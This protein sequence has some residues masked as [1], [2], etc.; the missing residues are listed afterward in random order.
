MK[1]LYFV[2]HGETPLN[3]EKLFSGQIETPLTKKGVAQARTTAKLIKQ[4]I[5]KIDLIIAS[6]YTRTTHTAQIIAER[7]GYPSDKIVFHD[8]LIERS[9]GDLEGTST[10]RYYKPNMHMDIDHIE[11]VET[12][13]DLQDRAQKALDLV[14]TFDDHDVILIVG[15]GSFGRALYRAANNLPH[16]H[17]FELFF[18]IDNAKLLEL[19]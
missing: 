14:R 17:E 15:H 6:P 9:Y 10:E 12:V 13:K 19:F 3:V 16:T 11:T 5:P 18:P 1:K 8:L 4:T 2:R 7:I